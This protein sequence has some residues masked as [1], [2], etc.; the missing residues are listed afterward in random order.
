MHGSGDPRRG[1]EGRG[2]CVCAEFGACWLAG[3]FL[4][5]DLVVSTV[6]D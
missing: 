2:V 6:P 3:C 5:W 4:A 1:E